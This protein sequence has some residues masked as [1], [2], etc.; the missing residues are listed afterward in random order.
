MSQLSSPTQD[1]A[2]S[3]AT[4]PGSPI[5]AGEQLT[6]RS[7]I[8]AL[9]A[10][11]DDDSDEEPTRTRREERVSGDLA[12]PKLSTSSPKATPF[13]DDVEDDDDDDDDDEDVILPRGKLARRLH[14]TSKDEEHVNASLVSDGDDD[15]YERV[16]KQLFQTQEVNGE[17]N[18]VDENSRHDSEKEVA[19]KKFGGFLRKKQKPEIPSGDEAA[20][21]DAAAKPSLQ[22]GSRSNE[23]RGEEVLSPDNAT[24]DIPN[25]EGDEAS[26]DDS[27]P[28]LPSN[29]LRNKR[30]EALVARKREERL[31]REAVE[32]AKRAERAAAARGSLNE[33]GTR[34]NGTSDI[35]EADSAD[36]DNEANL[37]LT[38]RSRPARKAS[39]KAMEEM[40]RETQ[41][42]SRNM[43]L[44]HEAKTRKKISKDSLLER[45]KLK[46]DSGITQIQASSSTV[47]SSAPTSDG[48]GTQ[49][50]L[51][52]LTT[53]ERTQSFKP[54]KSVPTALI[55]ETSLLGP[56]GD[57]ELPTLDE[58]LSSEVADKGK[59]KD[60]EIYPEESHADLNSRS[61]GKGKG[62]DPDL[63]PSERTTLGSRDDKPIAMSSVIP[64]T[65]K[66]AFTQRPIKLRP[67]KNPVAPQDCYADSSSDLEIVPTK[68]S[69]GKAKI[70]DRLPTG[71]SGEDKSLIRL[72]ALA[73]LSSP[74]KQRRASDKASMT[75]TELGSALRRQARLQAARERAEKMDE[76]RRKGVIIQSSEERQR[77]QLA[78]EDMLERARA[79]ENKLAQKEKEEFKKEKRE[80]GE[81]DGLDSS[82]DEEYVEGGEITSEDDADVELSGSEDE[83]VENDEQTDEDGEVDEE[84]EDEIEDEEQLV[85]QGLD[86]LI[87]DVASQCDDDEE[88]EEDIEDEENE[89]RDTGDSVG[90]QSDDESS[91]PQVQRRRKIMRVSD[92]EDDEDLPKTPKPTAIPE[93]SSVVANPFGQQAGGD[94]A[95]M[96]LTQAFAATMA[97]SQVG[98]DTGEEDSLAA[99]GALTAPEY[100]ELEMDSIVKDSQAVETQGPEVDLHFTQSQILPDSIPAER[101]AIATQFSQMPDPSQDGGFEKSSPITSRFVAPPPSTVDTV[102]I[103]QESVQEHL[104]LKKKGRLRKRA[105]AIAVFSDEENE[106]QGPAELEEE[107]NRASVTADA[108]EKLKKGSKK[109]KKREL[110]NK[111]KSAAKEVIE[112]QAVESEDEYAGL[113]GASDDS[114]GEEDEEIKKMIDEGDVK[115]DERKIAAYFA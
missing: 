101:A 9:L 85:K 52:P 113:G 43:Q 28:D 22:K 62:K 47:N 56:D 78:V 61:M 89:I 2:N 111:Q 96:S 21:L 68:A 20:T 70:F 39:K 29:P 48:E 75:P 105:E 54:T 86:G 91:I 108:F 12:A 53:P 104:V 110:F 90:G 23:E 79:E 69:S 41:R 98:L 114:E 17:Q 49:D 93:S 109:A 100:P 25:R 77:D 60:P 13:Q 58:A 73:H 103:P 50:K 45:F 82:D 8:K 83:H 4:T 84:D 14:N 64:E 74:G 81:D 94:S 40:A 88:R 33:N 7:K 16:R 87:D 1:A 5:A 32:E 106:D 27:D 66:P 71:K 3:R 42:L 76:L 115:D 18:R 35:S 102:I 72:R 95:P 31:A 57:E 30:F 107:I 46:K 38:Q 36:E 55:P 15:A 51:T 34:E 80:K 10:T 6:P 44:A 59:G 63:Y 37:K 24:S 11:L 65:R 26:K 19:P 67:P 112:E 97:D 99:L 92:D